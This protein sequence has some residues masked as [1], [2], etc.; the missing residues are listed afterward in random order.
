M[1]QEKFRLIEYKTDGEKERVVVRMPWVPNRDLCAV[2]CLTEKVIVTVWANSVD[3]AH[4]T[5]D[6]SVYD[7]NL[8]ILQ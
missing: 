4:L 2:L 7:E 3:D 6:L 1:G 8:K 5:L